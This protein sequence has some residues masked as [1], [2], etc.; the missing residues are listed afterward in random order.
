M[1]PV[2]FVVLMFV[3]VVMCATNYLAMHEWHHAKREQFRKFFA[4]F[5]ELE[6]TSSKILILRSKVGKMSPNSD[7][8]RPPYNSS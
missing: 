3:L 7:F 8:K 4:L 2:H 1:L 6:F 5:V